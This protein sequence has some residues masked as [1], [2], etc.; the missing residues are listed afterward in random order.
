MSRYEDVTTFVD[1]LGKRQYMG[2]KY[3]NVPLQQSDL[4][5]IC[6]TTDR[7]DTLANTY[8]GDPSLWWVIS[9]ANNATNQDG[10]YPPLDSYIRIPQDYV[11][12]LNKFNILND[13]GNN[14]SSY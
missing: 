13:L 12:V 2:V 3:P 8:Y 1:E 7:Y 9:I 6:N 5:I 14:A 10:L 11:G 4:Y